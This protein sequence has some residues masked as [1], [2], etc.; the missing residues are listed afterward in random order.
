MNCALGS[1]AHALPAKDLLATLQWYEEKRAFHRPFLYPEHTPDDTAVSRDGRRF[2]SSRARLTRRRR[3]PWTLLSNGKT[4][5]TLPRIAVLRS[6][7]INHT[8]HHRAQL[9]V[10]LRLNNIPVPALYGP[11][12]DEGSM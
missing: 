4:I 2:V 6:F 11:S 1:I 5:F 8:I 3:T 10:Y 9:G 12:A 7:V